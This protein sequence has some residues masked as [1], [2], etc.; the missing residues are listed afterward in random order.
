MEWLR[1]LRASL[2]EP[3]EGPGVPDVARARMRAEAG[4]MA[5]PGVVSIGVGLDDT[6]TK[7]IVVGVAGTGVDVTA[8]PHDVD[9]VPVLVREVGGYRADEGDA[10]DDAD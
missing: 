9:G 5:L 8:V 4:L 10:Q 2:E 1:R 7:A 6:G 3:E